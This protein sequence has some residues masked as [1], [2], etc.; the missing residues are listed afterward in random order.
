MTDRE[1]LIEILEEVEGQYNNDFPS[2]EQIAD[3]LI[4]N[5]VTFAT[6]N[7]VGSKWISVTD[8]LPEDRQRILCFKKS[9]YGSCVMVVTYSKCLESY[10]GVD[11]RGVKRGGFF[12]YDSEVGY[13]EIPD[14]T[15]WMPLPEAPKEVSDD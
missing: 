10:C 8:R 9:K 12:S 7:N 3:G 6:D 2:I 4:A 15:H 5:G 11:F 1:N 13:Y 14:V